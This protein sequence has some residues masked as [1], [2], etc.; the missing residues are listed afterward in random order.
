[1][2]IAIVVLV[3]LL[4]FVGFQFYGF[5]SDEVQEAELSQLNTI[6]DAQLK[7][8]TV[9]NPAELATYT[10]RVST[11]EHTSDDL[12]KAASLFIEASN[13]LYIHIFYYVD[14][15]LVQEEFQ[16]E[17]I[18]LGQI[19]KEILILSQNNEDIK[20]NL[21]PKEMVLYEIDDQNMIHITPKQTG[22]Y[23]ISFD[24]YL[25]TFENLEKK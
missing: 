21:K 6:N 17:S 25:I 7:T 10:H 24:K 23:Q 9:D 8:I 16:G 3:V 5:I 12:V 13:P 18:E 14:N 11:Y 19:N 2:K 22:L 1:M 20:T 4:A 15:M